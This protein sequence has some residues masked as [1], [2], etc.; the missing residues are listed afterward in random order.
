MYTYI[1]SSYLQRK[2]YNPLLLAI[3]TSLS[4]YGI[5]GDVRRLSN[6]LTIES[7]TRDV[8]RKKSGTVVVVGDDKTAFEVINC[9]AGS[10]IVFSFIPVEEKSHYGEI[11]GI[12]SGEAACEVIAARRLETVDLGYVDK[13]YFLESACTEVPAKI[14]LQC[15]DFVIET[16]KEFWVCLTNIG[17][18]SPCDGQLDAVI[19]RK[20]FFGSGA[21]IF[22]SIPLQECEL[23]T[24]KTQFL[25]LDQCQKA[26]LPAKIRVAPKALRVIVGK[27]R[28]F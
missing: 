6:F 25:I 14:A 24:H 12:P 27:N 4:S 1:Y 23:K 8:L 19:F 7:I 2:K 16:K 10:L 9:L 26:P 3:E 21:E 15:K 22:S 18:N 20:S 17:V 28:Q 11:L 5:S 13:R